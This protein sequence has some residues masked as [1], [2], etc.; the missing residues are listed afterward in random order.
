MSCSSCELIVAPDELDVEKLRRLLKEPWADATNWS[1]ADKEQVW[2]GIVQTLEELAKS[3]GP[4]TC[5]LCVRSTCARG[6]FTS[7][8]MH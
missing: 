6:P 8:S 7:A 5:T 2:S 1:K 3:F 4:N